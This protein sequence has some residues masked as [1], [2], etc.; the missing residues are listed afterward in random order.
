MVEKY[1]GLIVTVY[2]N[3]YESSNGGLSSKHQELTLLMD[4]PDERI[5]APTADRPAVQLAKIGNW[6]VARPVLPVPD[7][8]VSWMFGGTFIYSSDSRFARLN[9]GHPIPLHD[10]T[11]SYEMYRLLSS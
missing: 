8:N 2:R 3:K 1:G 4:N 6:I 5:F 10:R 9:G 7:G 11:E